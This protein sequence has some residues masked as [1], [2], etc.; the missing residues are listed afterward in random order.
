M[1]FIQ[2]PYYIPT[3]EDERICEYPSLSKEVENDSDFNPKNKKHVKE[4]ELA[5]RSNQ[6]YVRFILDL[7]Y[8]TD[9]TIQMIK[10]FSDD[11]ISMLGLLSF[12]K[13]K[14]M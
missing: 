7:A 5:A 13:D 1:A 10:K 11:H 3:T 8:A 2:I 4:M 12:T 9:D 6:D 14:L